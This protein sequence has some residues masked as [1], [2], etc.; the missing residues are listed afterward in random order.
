MSSEPEIIG[1]NESSHSID[2]HALPPRALRA[3]L[4]KLNEKSQTAIELYNDKYDI[5]LG[6]IEQ[7]IAK[8]DQEFHACK[9]INRSATATLLLSE[10]RRFDFRSWEEFCSFDSSQK[11][12]T[13]SLQIELNYSVFRGED[14]ILESYGIQLSIQNLSES[15][16]MGIMFGPIA[17]SQP[18]TFPVPPSP[19]SCTVK[20]NNY[21]L[22]KN[23]VSAADGWVASLD[24]I[25]NSLLKHA[26]RNSDK[27]RELVFFLATIFG[28]VAALSLHKMEIF[29]QEEWI[30][31]AAITVFSFSYFGR[32]VGKWIEKNI[33]RISV[34]DPLCITR[35][36]D[37]YA[38][39]RKSKNKR[40]II[41]AILGILIFFV[42][43][44][45]SIFSNDILSLIK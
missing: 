26:H 38:K 6:D 13:A 10:Q 1:P 23:L 32:F 36:D 18:G 39:S 24:V 15:G 12:R 11:G 33:D 43:A 34:R 7:F 2:V 28:L 42:Q 40:L 29:F 44:A 4:D 20:Y 37:Q 8:I 9:V 25:E 5:S 45:I 3:I 27:L 35:G 17:I 16:S 30:I 31:Y 22:G 41:K 14:Q 21:I 19:I